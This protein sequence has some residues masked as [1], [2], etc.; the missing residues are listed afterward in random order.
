[1]V[2]KLHDIPKSLVF[3]RD[4]IFIDHFWRD[5][6]TFSEIKL[7]MSISYHPET[8]GQTE[9]L[10]KTLEQY[11]QCFFIHDSPSKCGRSFYHLP[12][13]ATILPC[14]PPLALLTL[15]LPTTY[16]L[17]PLPHT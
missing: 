7:R 15:K 13:G 10:N 4:Q 12:N 11:L 1:M 5:L 8:D 14:T 16:P 6:F 17:L 3:N 2:C 9:V